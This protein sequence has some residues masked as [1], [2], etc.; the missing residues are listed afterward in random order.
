MPNGGV[1]PIM[2]KTPLHAVLTAMAEVFSLYTAS[3]VGDEAMAG[4]GLRHV[5]TFLR[6]EDNELIL[7]RVGETPEGVEKVPVTSTAWLL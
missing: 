7:L 4:Q 1:S 3:V 5:Q 6:P 2:M